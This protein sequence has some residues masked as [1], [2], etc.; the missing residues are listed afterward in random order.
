M[1]K[2]LFMFSQEKCNSD[3]SCVTWSYTPATLGQDKSYSKAMCYHVFED[4]IVSEI[5]LIWSPHAFVGFKTCSS[6]KRC[7]H[8]F[9]GILGS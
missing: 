4:D 5:S 9:I 6:G 1:L 2:H 8:V 3:S 7:N